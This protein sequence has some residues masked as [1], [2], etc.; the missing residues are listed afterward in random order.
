MSGGCFK[1]LRSGV[2][3]PYAKGLKILTSG[4]YKS[5]RSEVINSYVPHVEG[6]K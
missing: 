4:G 6:P 3:N 5:L 2:I 1:S